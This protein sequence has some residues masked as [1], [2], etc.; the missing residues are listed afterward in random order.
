MEHLKDP[1]AHGTF[2]FS[3]R[4]WTCNLWIFFF[5]EHETSPWSWPW[6]VGS[7]KWVV[8]FLKKRWHLEHLVKTECI[9]L[10]CFHKNTSYEYDPKMCSPCKIR[11]SAVINFP[12]QWLLGT[13]SIGLVAGSFWVAGSPWQAETLF[14]DCL[15]LVE[16]IKNIMKMEKYDDCWWLSTKNACIYI[17]IISNNCL[18]YYCSQYYHNVT[19]I[20]FFSDV[21]KRTPRLFSSQIG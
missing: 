20:S 8:I 5:L 14:D 13:H 3:I 18:L 17:Y 16:S 12:P 21:L 6:M 11:I 9:S 1:L 15:N 4:T 19:I 7:T 2:T 10:S